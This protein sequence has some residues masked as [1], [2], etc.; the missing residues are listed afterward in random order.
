MRPYP[1]VRAGIAACA[2]TILVTLVAPGC[3]DSSSTPANVAGNYT[4]A[5]TNRDNG[6]AFQNFT[7]GNTASNIPF[8]VTQSGSNVSG[9]IQGLVGTWVSLVFGSNQFKGAV[10]GD[11]LNMTLYG[12]RS[13]TQGNCTY[14]VNATV[15]ATSNGDVLQGH[16]DYSKVGNGNPD[17]AGITG[18][19]TRQDFNG[20]RPPQ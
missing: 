7:P 10:S 9:T 5:V 15:T 8:A 4:I 1:R 3:G 16:I 13:A 17:C 11:T 6:C 12:T 18:C 2:S 14:T 20:T 19:I